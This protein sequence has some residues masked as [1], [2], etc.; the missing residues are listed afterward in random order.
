M[1]SGGRESGPEEPSPDDGG[2]RMA[3]GVLPAL[4][5][6]LA[7]LTVGRP[8]GTPPWTGDGDAAV[9]AADGGSGA[10]AGS[11]APERLTGRR[12]AHGA[13]FRLAS[14]RPHPFTEEVRLEFVLEPTLFESPGAE[15]GAGDPADAPAP[16]R[17]TLRIYD[18]FH[19]EV[20]WAE[21][22]SPERLRGRP[23]RDL[24]YRKPGRY[25]ARWDGRDAAGRRLPQGAYF[26]RLRLGEEDQVRK[27]LLAR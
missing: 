5:L 11:L 4:V 25:E 26:A 24:V 23:V 21:A 8:A 17:V 16:V 2:G 14:P 6:L 19:R 12:Q 10:A 18:L 27:L 15:D 13:G 22:V 7:L 3:R 20:G 1:R 9:S